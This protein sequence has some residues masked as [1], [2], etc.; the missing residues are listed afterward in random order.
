MQLSEENLSGCQLVELSECTRVLAIRGAQRRQEQRRRLAQADTDH[1]AARRQH[2]AQKVQH[3]HL[4]N[5]AT[6]AVHIE[7]DQSRQYGW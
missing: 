5:E 7:A 2:L 4:V 3:V 1:V 6:R